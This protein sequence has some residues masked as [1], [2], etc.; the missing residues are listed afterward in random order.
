MEVP[1]TEF[2]N[3]LL[4]E[5]LYLKIIIGLVGMVLIL[6]LAQLIQR[7]V[8]KSVESPDLRYRMRKMVAFLGYMLVILY[9][10]GVFS[11]QLHSIAVALGVASAG[12]AFALQEVIV[13]IA[14]WLA[15]SFGRF[16]KIGDRVQLSGTVGDVIDIGVF[17]TTLMEIG[18]WVKADQYSGRVVRIANSFVFT[19]PVYNFSADFPYIWDEIVL[20]VKYGSDIQ[21]VRSILEQA[22]G[23][24]VGEYL[25]PA[26]THWKAIYSKYRLEHE[27]IEPAVTLIANDNWLEF[28]LRYIVDYKKRRSTKDRLF[29]HI[30]QEIDKSEGKVAIASTTLQLVDLP[31][32]KLDLLDKKVQ[33]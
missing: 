29:E 4:N 14:G 1:V 20:P 27:S 18:E 7:T 25:E 6:G 21:L 30:L 2:L 5:P 9:L 13:S 24:V 26:Q 22:A 12:I 15:I 3:I 33:Q 23:A 11:E 8:T 31:L 16:Y 28:A 19:E 17:A 10:A 32:I